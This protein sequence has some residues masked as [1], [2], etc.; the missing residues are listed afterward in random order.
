MQL[1]QAINCVPFAAVC[2]V[3]RDVMVY[4]GFEGWLECNFERI[5]MVGPP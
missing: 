5:S 4:R 3:Y 1:F 2:G